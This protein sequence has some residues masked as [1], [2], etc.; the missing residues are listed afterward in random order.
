ML[1]ALPSSAAP[2]KPWSDPAKFPSRA[3][4]T[5][6]LHAVTALHDDVFGPGALTR[7]A[8]R[9]REGQPPFTPY[10]RVVLDG[11]IVPVLPRP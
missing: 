11:K 1:N 6:D 7:S 3:M 10:C 5:A 4:T 2:A 8:Y 9:V